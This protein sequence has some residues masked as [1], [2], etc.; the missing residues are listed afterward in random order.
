[1]KRLDAHRHRESKA[2]HVQRLAKREA[3]RSW[4]RAKR[5]GGDVLAAHKALMRAVRLH[6]DFVRALKRTKDDLERK[7]ARERFLQ[8]PHRYSKRPVNTSKPREAN[9][10]ERGGRWLLSA[11]LHG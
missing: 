11:N 7:K 6:H 1:M 8:D 9:L 4:R 5:E 2:L 10:Y 3:R